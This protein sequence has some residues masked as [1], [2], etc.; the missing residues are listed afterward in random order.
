[1]LEVIEVIMEKNILSWTLLL[2]HLDASFGQ[3]TVLWSFNN[4]NTFFLKKDLFIAF[5]LYAFHIVNCFLKN[6]TFY[7]TSNPISTSAR[8]LSTRQPF[9]C[10]KKCKKTQTQQCQFGFPTLDKKTLLMQYIR[11]QFPVGMPVHVTVATLNNFES[12]LKN[13]APLNGIQI[14]SSELL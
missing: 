9:L 11:G 2:G 4:G 14:Y 12:V 3:G 6:N 5:I 8:R 1:M 10:V 13:P 7:L